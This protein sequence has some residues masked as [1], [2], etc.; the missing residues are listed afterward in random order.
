M[1][2]K[3]QNTGYQVQ[4]GRVVIEWKQTVLLLRVRVVAGRHVVL[5]VVRL[6]IVRALQIVE[7]L[8]H[9]GLLWLTSSLVFPGWRERNVL[10]T[11]M[12]WINPVA[13]IEGLDWIERLEWLACP[14]GRWSHLVSFSHFESPDQTYFSFNL[15]VRPSR[16]IAHCE[17]YSCNACVS[18]VNWLMCSVWFWSRLCMPWAAMFSDCSN[19]ACARLSS[20]C[21]ACEDGFLRFLQS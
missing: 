17:W 13:P 7:F 19:F 2:R 8:V 10:V 18:A 6:G 5:I 21:S 12:T 1:I 9:V 15:D 20:T 4:G 11:R 3:N 16:I 14:A